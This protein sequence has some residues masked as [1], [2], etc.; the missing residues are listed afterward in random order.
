MPWL[1]AV[2]LLLLLDDTVALAN[3]RLQRDDDGRLRLRRTYDFEYS[4]TGDN[5]R[6]AQLALLGDEVL[7]LRLAP[8]AAA[9]SRLRL[10]AGR[11]DRKSTRLNSS[12]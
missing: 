7:L 9:G 3:L 2:G 12:H 8:V 5:R 10:A 4:D 6:A 11:E 1:E